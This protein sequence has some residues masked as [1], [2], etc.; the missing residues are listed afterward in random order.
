MRL[1]TSMIYQQN[2]NGILD[3]QSI[4]QKSGEQ[5]ASGKRV[6]NPSDDPIAASQSIMI[7]QS[8]AETEQYKLARTF[9]RQGM[10]FE[11]SI[12][13]STVTAVTSALGEVTSAGGVR[14]ND[15]RN[16]HALVLEGIKAQ[17]LN[18]ANTTDGNGSYIFAGYQTDK[19]PFVED[20]VTKKV[21][22]VGGQTS[23]SQQ[24]DASR[25][26][27]VS[28]IGSQVFSGVTGD[29]VKEPDGSATQ[30]DLFET[31]D[32]AIAALKTPIAEGDT[33]AQEALSAALDKANRGLRNSVNNL[34][35]VESS[36]GVQ[37]DELDKLDS[38]GEDRKLANTEAQ[39]QLQD[40][41]WVAAISAYIMKQSSLQASYTTFQNMQGMSLFQINR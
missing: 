13:K 30:S 32:I 31:L 29:A 12:I 41:D 38:I 23:I 40:T 17:L 15:D 28:H 20:P 26:M 16:T 19:P 39:S 22:Y 33:A 35:A 10:S 27:T 9:A 6:V 3:N 2:L 14:T 5:L 7:G 24:V 36:L 18:I 37:L 34:S 4:W 8:Q 11:A 21:S 1:S 25:S